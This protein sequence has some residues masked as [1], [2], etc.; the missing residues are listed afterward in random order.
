MDDKNVRTQSFVDGIGYWN[1][2]TK[3]YDKPI[4]ACFDLVDNVFDAAP[5]FRG[6]LKIDVDVEDDKDDEDESRE[7]FTFT[8]ANSGDT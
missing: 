5:L 1:N 3:Q 4:M 7:V 2:C 6:L 8:V